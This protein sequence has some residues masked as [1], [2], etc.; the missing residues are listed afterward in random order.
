MDTESVT[1]IV[2]KIKHA[3]PL[4]VSVDLHA[5]ADKRFVEAGNRSGTFTK[6]AIQS[7]KYRASSLNHYIKVLCDVLVEF[8][9][10]H[11][12]KSWL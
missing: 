10:V 7:L 4:K 6:K 5:K 12:S 3:N 8:H 2:E 11:A 9:Q 1:I